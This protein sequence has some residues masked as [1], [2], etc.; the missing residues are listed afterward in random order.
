A[1]LILTDGTSILNNVPDSDDVHQMM[2][3]LVDLGAQVQ[4]YPDKQQLIVNTTTL[5]KYSVRAEIMRK[6]RAS[7]LVLGPL[8]ARFTKAEIAMPG[9]DQIG[10]RPIDIHLK[11]FVRMGATVHVE[12]DIVTAS[13]PKLEARTLVL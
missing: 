6:I 4:F 9:G 5:N 7:A 2:A 1:S 3:L 8:L 13:A 11:N 10:T 12:G